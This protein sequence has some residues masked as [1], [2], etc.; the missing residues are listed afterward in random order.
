[1]LLDAGGVF[2]GRPES[3]M[4]NGMPDIVGM[5]TLKY[6][7][8]AIGIPE[9]QRTAKDFELLNQKCEFT[10]L[11]ANIMI[12]NK[13]AKRTE[14]LSDDYF[15]KK[16][17]GLKVGIFSV[18]SED[19]KYLIRP[20]YQSEYIISDPVKAANSTASKLKREK[21]CDIVIALTYLGYY[22]EDPQAM[23][24]EALANNVKNVDIII[25]GRTSVDNEDPDIIN[26]IPIFQV[27]KWGLSVGEVNLI[28][29]NNKVADWNYKI[30][31]VNRKVNGEY[32][33]G[34]TYED[35]FVTLSAIKGAMATYDAV[36]SAR[37][38]KADPD[39]DFDLA[40]IRFAECDFGN[41]LCDA[42]LDFTGA[43]IVL[44]NTGGINPSAKIDP[45]KITRKS[46]DNVITF[47]NPVVVIAMT[48]K[49][50]RDSLQY[51]ISRKGYG[52]FLQIA[53][54]TCEYNSKGQVFNVSK[55]GLPLDD[56]IQY[57]VAVSSW[58]LMGGDGYGS[59]KNC[60]VK[61]EASMLIREIFYNYIEE[62][63]IIT[64]PK[65]GRINA[66]D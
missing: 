59:L 13:I 19:A 29:K 10:Y 56:H 63:E 18:I 38:C 36:A 17:G 50:I 51:S 53:G 15:I 21:N 14:F 52:S 42:V 37:L 22:P 9:L 8:A 25:D 6:D 3:N 46:F 65:G 44:M 62:K 34:K 16:V 30:H 49:E 45:N 33:G 54:I 20:A 23:D 28:I 11:G 43:D 60:P 61:T 7:C 2:G 31:S 57:R 64:V 35:D 58:M 39:F 26:E 24:T 40:A 1:L 55:N 5:N 32:V 4:L 27:G 41:L 66:V 47:D 12:M 48:G